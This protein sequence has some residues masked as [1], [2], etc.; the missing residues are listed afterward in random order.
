MNAL[1]RRPH[2]ARLLPR[3][4]LVV[5]L[6]STTAASPSSAHQEQAA[7]E[8]PGIPIT[9][10]DWCGDFSRR[11]VRL[12][13]GWSSADSEWFYWTSQGSQLLPYA[14]FVALE[15]ADDQALFRD[16]RNMQ[17]YRML[18][19]RPS[20]L[21]PHGLPVG[22][23]ADPGPVLSAD[24]LADR[25]AVGFTCAACHTMQI[26]YK[27]TA[28]R[29]DGATALGDMSRLIADL[30][31]ALHATLRDEAKFQRFA[32]RVI[33]ANADAS[34]RAALRSALRDVAQERAAYERR[35]RT[36][37]AE[38]P[39]RLDAFGRIYSSALTLVDPKNRHSPDAPVSFP[40]LWNTPRFDRVQFTAI[41][42]NTG[43][44]PL[45]R[46][47]GQIV[48]VFGMIDPGNPPPTV[49]Y[50]SSIRFGNL[51]A[52]EHR[53]TKLKSPVWPEDILPPIDRA[54][55][56][57][58]REVFAQ[59]CNR[60]H[61]DHARD[62]LR[63]R[64]RVTQV[65]IWKV[66]TD[67]RAAENLMKTRGSTGFLAGTRQ[68]VI[69]GKPMAANDTA[70]HITRNTVLH[71]LLGKIS[72]FLND[73]SMRRTAEI[74][75]FSDAEDQLKLEPQ[76]QYKARPLNGIWSTAPFL[77]NG[78]VPTLYE[79]ISDP[80]RRTKRFA[81]GRREFDPVKVGFR[82]EPREGTFIFDTTLPGNTNTGHPFGKHLS[83][84][85][86]WAVVEYLKTL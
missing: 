50:A 59:S 62:D 55:A 7:A 19:E 68:S 10:R 27:G 48:G 45:M 17:K 58:G 67:A 23:V 39:G 37:L 21:N 30:T 34:Q 61:Q 82:T 16:A 69:V 81:V 52:L 74:K 24:L 79:M 28:M 4:A 83:E 33:G 22:L 6:S 80:V 43:I 9:G 2:G 51:R 3:V 20:A 71:L 70:F 54:R 5:A 40:Q 26:N 56:A 85:E 41:A 73:N 31:A 18:P 35:N 11:V 47:I 8:V 15:Q 38:G 46:N 77:H 72:P 86:R 60:C 66:R 25:R 44:G 64:I 57:H 1:G 14:F 75:A 49:G 76:M 84:A 63:S 32:N 78:S 36:T 13:Q 29:I 65:P 12:E 42:K 53:L